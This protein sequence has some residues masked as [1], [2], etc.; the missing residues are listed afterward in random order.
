VQLLVIGI[1]VVGTLASTLMPKGAAG[2]KSFSR[3][4]TFF[5]TIGMA[6]FTVIGA[7]LALLAGLSWCWAAFCAA[8]TCAGGGMTQARSAAVLD[9]RIG[10]GGSVAEQRCADQ[11]HVAAVDEPGGIREAGTGRVEG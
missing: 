7:K 4:L 3:W 8:L 5:D 2:T 10:A 6:T 1:V 11:R 9:I